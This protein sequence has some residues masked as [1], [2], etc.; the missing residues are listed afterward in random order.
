[1]FLKIIGIIYIIWL[2]VVSYRI[3]TFFDGVMSLPK[4]AA[5]SFL[6]SIITPIMLVVDLLTI[7]LTLFLPDDETLEKIFKDWFD[8]EK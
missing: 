2:I 5:A 7:V 3:G 4:I 8:R 1:M 6:I